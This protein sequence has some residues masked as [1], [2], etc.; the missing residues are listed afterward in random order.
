LFFNRW[1]FAVRSYFGMIFVHPPDEQKGL[2][3]ALTKGKIV[4]PAL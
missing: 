3:R 4:Y 1:Y 2:E